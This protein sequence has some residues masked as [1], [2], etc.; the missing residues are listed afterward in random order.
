M[1]REDVDDPA[2][3][4][5]RE[6]HLGLDHPALRRREQPS[7]SLVHRGVSRVE[8]PC[9]VGAVPSHVR[10]EARAERG[11]HSPEFPERY[12]PSATSFDAS[13]DRRRYARSSRKVDLPPALSHPDRP[14][15]SADTLVIHPGSMG[16]GP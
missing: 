1:P 15:G 10:L 16:T 5:D 9:Q 4:M 6:R 12:R 11:G 2:L 14:Q 8:E 7:D 3:T 13:D